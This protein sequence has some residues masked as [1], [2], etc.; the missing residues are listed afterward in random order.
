MNLPF[1]D[2]YYERMRADEIETFATQFNSEYEECK[3][4]YSAAKQALIEGLGLSHLFG[5]NKKKTPEEMEIWTLFDR[6]EVAQ[7]IARDALAKGAYMQGADDREKM[8]R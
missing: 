8:I 5:G 6:V 2:E 7:L 3:R 1:M 4:E